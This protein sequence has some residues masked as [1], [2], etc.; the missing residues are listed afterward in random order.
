[1]IAIELP[2]R[3]VSESNARGHWAPRARRAKWQRDVVAL[4]TRP[5]IVSLGLPVTVRLTRVAPRALDDDNLRGA[6][7]ACRDGVAD[8]LGVRDNDPRVHWVYGQRRGAKAAYAV[9]IVLTP[10]A[11]A[12]D[13]ENAS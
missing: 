7:K 5:R 3:T 9:E 11:I 1:V 12:T 2:I 13:L 10:V 4:A 8:A 6:L